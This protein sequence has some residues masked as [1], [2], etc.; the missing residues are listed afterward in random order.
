M[1]GEST[2]HRKPLKASVFGS[3]VKALPLLLD[4]RNQ[5]R[6]LIRHFKV[7]FHVAE[8]ASLLHEWVVVNLK[9]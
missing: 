4:L 9:R 2:A 3:E 7:A 6:F 1:H 8:A 5:I